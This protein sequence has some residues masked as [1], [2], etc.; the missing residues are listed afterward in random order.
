MSAKPAIHAPARSHTEPTPRPPAAEPDEP[1]NQGWD[2]ESQRCGSGQDY[3]DLHGPRICAPPLDPEADVS[4]GVRLGGDVKVVASADGRP[5]RRRRCLA[6]RAASTVSPPAWLVAYNLAS[7]SR[8]RARSYLVPEAAVVVLPDLG[9]RHGLAVTAGCEG[10]QLAGPVEPRPDRGA[11]AARVA[12][13]GEGG[14]VRDL[15]V[16]QHL[17]VGIQSRGDR[18]EEPRCHMVRTVRL[19]RRLERGGRSVTVI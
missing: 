6:A 19:A 7:S 3:G 18:V 13:P 16:L 15:L 8:L 14:D 11:P 5:G 4:P 10:H 2:R 17:L 9:D 12:C 1:G